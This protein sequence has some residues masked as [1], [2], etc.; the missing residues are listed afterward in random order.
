[1]DFDTAVELPKSLFLN[2]C[3]WEKM[4]FFDTLRL[5]N[6]LDKFYFLTGNNPRFQNLQTLVKNNLG[7]SIFQSIEK[8]KIEL[9]QQESVNLEYSKQGIEINEPISI[10]EFSNKI[11]ASDVSKIRTY[12]E[13]F[14]QK[15]NIKSDEIDTVFMTGGTSLAKPIRD[16]IIDLFGEESLKSGDNFNSVAN[17]LAYSHVLFFKK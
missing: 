9:S 16:F 8:A 3:S 6:A 10:A 15:S 5:K 11:V 17:G 13:D 12:L 4:N 1:M 7:Y 14:L 2:I